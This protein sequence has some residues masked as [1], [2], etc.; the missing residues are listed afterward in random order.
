MDQTNNNSDSTNPPE[1][2]AQATPS[3]PPLPIKKRIA[4]VLQPTPPEPETS[5]KDQQDSILSE[6]DEKTS[7]E[8]KD[9]GAI[10]P[11][12]APGEIEIGTGPN[13]SEMNNGEEKSPDAEVMA[14]ADSTAVS[15]VPQTD[16]PIA[17]KPEPAK[18]AP[19]AKPVETVMIDPVVADEKTPQ[20]PD[21]G[22]IV[23]SPIEI[24]HSIGDLH[25]WAPGLI[26]YLINKKLATIEI[27][28][29]PLQDN[30]GLLD[31]EIL[32]KIFPEP[33]SRLQ[34]TGIPV[35]AGLSKQ[36]GFE[37]DE[38]GLN[39]G[40]HG[41]IKAR[42]IAEPNVALIQIGDIYDRADHSELAAEIL[43]QLIIDAP[44][45]VFVMVGNHEQFMLENDYNNWYF[46]EARNAFTE[47]DSSP[48]PNTRN[49]FRFFPTWDGKTNTERAEA[50]FERY[51]HSTWTLF[52]TQGAV[53][54]KLGWIDNKPNLDSMLGSGWAGYESSRKIKKQWESDSKQKKIP[55]ALTAL[56]I[57]DT[58]FH[59]AEPAAHRTDDG[60][61]LEIPLPDTMKIVK[62]KS[63]K[64]LLR[65]YTTGGGALKQSPDAPLLWSRGSSSGASSGAPAAESHL[66]G[67]ASA[68]KGL[69][70]IIHGH[71][72]T[73]GSGDFDSVTNG[74]STTVSYLGDSQGRQ[75]SKGR[76]NGIRIY[77]IDEGMSPAYYAGAESVYS[78]QRMPT[79]LRLEK[80]EFSPVEAKSKD[81]QHIH[82]DPSHSIDT[83]SRN[84]WRWAAGEWRNSTKPNWGTDGPIDTSQLIN[85]GKWKGFISTEAKSG[86]S[87]RDLLNRIIN[88]TQ[89][90]KLMIEK[91]LQDILKEE[92]SVDIT[93]PKASILER[94]TP[95]GV[96][97]VN[98]QIKKAWNAIEAVIVLIKENDKGG[99]SLI[100]LNSTDREA[101]IT[102]MDATGTKPKAHKS[103]IEEFKAKSVTKISIN[104]CGRLFISPSQKVIDKAFREWALGEDGED[105]NL[106]PVLA[107]YSKS[108]TPFKKLKISQ[109]T[110]ESLDPPK[111][112]PRTIPDP[113]FIPKMPPTPQKTG[114]EKNK[115]GWYEA[116]KDYLGISSN[117]HTANKTPMSQQSTESREKERNKQQ[118]KQDQKLREQKLHNQGSD[119]RTRGQVMRDLGSSNNN[120]LGT[121]EPDMRNQGTPN[122]ASSA[123]QTNR[124]TSG[125]KSASRPEGPKFSNHPIDLIKI[126]VEDSDYK[127]LTVY[128][129]IKEN[130]KGQR[131]GMLLLAKND[132]H[133][134]IYF[135]FSI[136]RD[137]NDRKI[138][139]T[140]RE[141]STPI[142]DV[143]KPILNESKNS[144]LVKEIIWI[145]K[146]LEK[147]E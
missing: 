26:S 91:M 51:V 118:K 14:E 67:L 70:R 127:Q 125:G 131:K 56:V 88:A 10:E 5:G 11:M 30:K 81:S 50:T 12:N 123:K 43:R 104:P 107:H 44:G 32:K 62:S 60:Q 86:D 74:K 122:M 77:N 47:K 102:I 3:K 145:T 80:D 79:G 7:P 101:K 24:L 9:K 17:P 65:M 99:Y 129:A 69:R 78:P 142:Q 2:E 33:I 71:T 64:I 110:S 141:P 132:H 22:E 136:S 45:R 135:D 1:E 111:P 39:D 19:P 4:G 133:S 90:G 96:H 36:P 63:N 140:R 92:P 20:T 35:K 73:V 72:P 134:K 109:I 83:D 108:K 61:G 97:I 42:W 27:D 82:I 15:E 89:I 128:V 8:E 115:K 13:D 144:A 34:T 29:Y 52:L 114:K 116:S 119:A 66:E 40:G 130:I 117:S 37:G 85:H 41:K 31:V 126:G 59:H 58:L 139:I 49:H 98:G 75:S 124:G 103:H 38:T 16:A 84:L 113:P 87:T 48:L 106:E 18:P 23:D 120:N 146:Q 46:N 21:L 6:L 57:G 28:G 147:I 25:G 68:W 138:S 54:Q 100:C 137:G 121:D 55:G 76:A 94:I 112:K 93:S 53:M 105:S 143:E 95:V